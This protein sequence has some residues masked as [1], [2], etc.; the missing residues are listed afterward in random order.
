LKAEVNASRFR[1]DLYYRLNVFEINIPPLRKQLEDLP[2]LEDPH[3][4]PLERQRS[5]ARQCARA[6]DDIGQ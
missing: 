4:A 3:V 1:E 2:A 6:R 5:R